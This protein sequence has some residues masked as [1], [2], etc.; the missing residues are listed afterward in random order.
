MT[1]TPLVKDHQRCP[2]CG[3]EG[4]TCDPETCTCDEPIEEVI[5]DVEEAKKQSNLIRDF[6]E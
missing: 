6:E 1:D 2:K 5:A 3:R 4:C